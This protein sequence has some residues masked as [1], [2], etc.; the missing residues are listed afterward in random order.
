MNPQA[1][2]GSRPGVNSFFLND[3]NSIEELFK[4][5]SPG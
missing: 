2:R 3:Y 4:L 1:P 5:Y